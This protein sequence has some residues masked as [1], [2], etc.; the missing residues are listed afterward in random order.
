LNCGAP[1]AEEAFSALELGLVADWTGMARSAEVNA[2][3]LALEGGDPFA[4]V[5]AAAERH[6]R[7]HARVATCGLYPAGPRVMR[8]AASLTRAA[9]ARRILDLGTGF[10]YSAL[11]L[12]EAAGADAHV[13]AIDQFSEHVAEAE[14]FARLAGLDDRVRFIQGDV[15]S[16]LDGLRAAPPYDQVHDDAWFAAEP[17]YFERVLELLRPGGLLTMPSWFL[18]TDALAGVRHERWARFGGEAWEESTRAYAQR[19]AADPRLA[20][21]FTTSPPLGIAIKRN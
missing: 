13:D 6:R 4:H 10:G 7:G 16:V 12:A 1:S 9:G 19:L 18:L 21:T 2:Q 14:R 8:L 3:L 11:W 20:V 5:L 17:P 15:R